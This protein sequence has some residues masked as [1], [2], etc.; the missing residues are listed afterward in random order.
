MMNEAISLSAF[1]HQLR[2]RYS[3]PRPN[4]GPTGR[5]RVK[6]V[7]KLKSV[8]RKTLDWDR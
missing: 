8:V 4:R 7:Q 6:L 3:E 1:S 2:R 5:G